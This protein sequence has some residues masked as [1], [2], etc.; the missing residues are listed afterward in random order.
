MPADLEQRIAVA[1]GWPV[2]AVRSLSAASLRELVR[3]VSPKL[4]RELDNLI[5]SGRVLFS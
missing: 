2:V 4:A 5:R 1:L 3:P